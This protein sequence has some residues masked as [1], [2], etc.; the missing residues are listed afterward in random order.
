[1]Q[2]LASYSMAMGGAILGI[3]PFGIFALI[4]LQKPDVKAGFEE[5]E[6]GPDDDEDEDKDDED[7][8]DEDD[9]DEDEDDEEENR[10]GKKKKGKR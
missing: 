3:L 9:Q 6:G 7:D 10:K 4:M 8:E 2:E 1:M 5:S